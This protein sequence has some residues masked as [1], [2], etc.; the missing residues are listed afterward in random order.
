MLT[1]KQ[2]KF[3]LVC[4]QGTVCHVTATKHTDP[5]SGSREAQMQMAL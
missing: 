3:Y 2:G 1:N 4:T 5:S